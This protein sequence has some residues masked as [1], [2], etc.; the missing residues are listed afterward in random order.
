VKRR[1]RLRGPD[2]VGEALDLVPLQLREHAY[3][4]RSLWGEPSATIDWRFWQY[5]DTGNVP[6]IRGDVDLN[7]FSGAPALWQSVLDAPR[8]P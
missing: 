8:A 2:E 7:V 3:W 6:G 1:L 5:S 4:V